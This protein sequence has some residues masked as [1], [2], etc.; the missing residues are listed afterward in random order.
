LPD[1]SNLVRLSLG[2]YS[3]YVVSYA[4]EED[5]RSKRSGNFRLWFV[6]LLGSQTD[7][8]AIWARLLKGEVAQV[9]GH[10]RY[11]LFWAT[12]AT[13]DMKSWKSFRIS[14]P[15]S[16]GYHLILVHEEVL[17]T[18]NN[19][20]FI[21]LSRPPAE[22]ADLHYRYLNHRLDV[23]LHPTWAKWLFARADGNGEAKQIEGLG[24]QAWKCLPYP[25]GIARDIGY[26][27][28][29]GD[30]R[31]DEVAPRPLEYWEMSQREFGESVT[32]KPSGSMMNVFL[33]DGTKWLSPA[34]RS[35]YTAISTTHKALV[36][37]ALDQKKRVPESVLAEYPDL[38]EMALARAK[39]G[40]PIH[41]IP[42]L[43]FLAPVEE[44]EEA[45]V[46]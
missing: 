35:R 40:I 32:I 18:S 29:R 23:P 28:R 31:V 30:L 19:Q 8:K 25:D 3:A 34:N 14:L 6:S 1:F 12:L 39:N 20:S 21:L 26:A 37:Q 41:R 27:I 4:M 9:T 5:D 22:T 44:Q 11:K 17:C 36:W 10:R 42:N 16:A 45:M 33:R 15:T 43:S 13:G 2:G 38:R 24:V 46:G 7:V